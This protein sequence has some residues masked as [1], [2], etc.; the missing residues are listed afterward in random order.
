MSHQGTHEHW[1]Q[2]E[3]HENLCRSDAS[4]RT[5]RSASSRKPLGDVV[6]LK[7]YNFC[8]S[9]PCGIMN[10]PAE[11]GQSIRFRN[12]GA[13]YAQSVFDESFHDLGAE[14]CELLLHRTSLRFVVIEIGQFL[15]DVGNHG[16]KE[17]LLPGKMGVDRRLACRRYLR[18]L[19]DAGAL[20][21]SFEEDFLSSVQNPRSD[22]AGQIPG[23]PAETPVWLLH[24]RLCRH[25]HLT[26]S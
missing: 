19:V 1:K 15:H 7:G 13:G 12:C 26:L 10:L 21:S 14:V 25:D 24:V 22:I 11:P 16:G 23:R 18:D 4:F 3:I 2:N 9:I 6:Q 20:I 5:K 8:S 17:C